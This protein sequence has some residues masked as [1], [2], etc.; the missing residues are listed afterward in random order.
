MCGCGVTIK[1]VGCE[2]CE[3]SQDS[4]RMRK[5]SPLSRVGQLSQIITS[6]EITGPCSYAT[7]HSL[8]QGVY[9]EGLV[10]LFEACDYKDSIA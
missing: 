7:Y 8:L 3:A 2:W 1:N 4:G 9:G 5:V 6:C 10:A